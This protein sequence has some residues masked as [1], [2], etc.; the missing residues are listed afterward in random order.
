MSAGG[1]LP[2]RCA[3]EPLGVGPRRLGAGV[4]ALQEHVFHP[5]GHA[6]AAQ[7]RVVERPEEEVAAEDLAGA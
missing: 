5:H 3:T 2:N 7:S 6:H 1:R 4:A